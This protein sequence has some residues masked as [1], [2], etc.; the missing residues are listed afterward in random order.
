MRV[1]KTGLGIAALCGALATIAVSKNRESAAPVDDQPELTAPTL[2]DHKLPSLC[3]RA[4]EPA[5]KPEKTEQKSLVEVEEKSELENSTREKLEKY[6]RNNDLDPTIKTLLL[7]ADVV[8][9]TK[10]AKQ[11]A[12]PWAVDVIREH[13]SDLEAGVAKLEDYRFLLSEPGKALEQL[14]KY[15]NALEISGAD[16]KAVLEP[17]YR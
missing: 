6:R 15:R 14:V 17:T 7:L 16:P 3:G 1:S 5:P 9:S 4:L 13:K 12:F 10:D 8:E 11:A 2:E